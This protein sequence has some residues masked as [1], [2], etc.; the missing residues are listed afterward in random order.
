MTKAD[1]IRALLPC[2]L[3]SREIA[4]QVDCRPEYVR[5]VKC[6]DADPERAR[7]WGRSRYRSPEY[8]AYNRAKQREFQRR[9]RQLEAA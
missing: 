8:R 5:A 9:K 4:E 7:E 1:R 2:E 6:R 3:T